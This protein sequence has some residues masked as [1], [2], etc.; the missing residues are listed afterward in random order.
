MPV[1]ASGRISHLALRLGLPQLLL[2]GERACQHG[3]RHG[4]RVE[5]QG[6][7]VEAVAPR[8]LGAQW[9]RD[10]KTGSGLGNSEL[11]LG[12]PVMKGARS[13]KSS[14]RSTVKKSDGKAS[15]PGPMS[16]RATSSECSGIAGQA[17]GRAF[18][19]ST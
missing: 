4:S 8:A 5:R 12:A 19:R 1:S 9:R 16:Q 13:A 14:L 6:W 18:S 3:S 15:S 11:Q 10:R 2:C 7:K 17:L